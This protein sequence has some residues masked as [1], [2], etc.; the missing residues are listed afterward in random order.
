MA[1]LALFVSYQDDY[2][3]AFLS[4]CYLIFWE[5]TH[6]MTHTENSLLCLPTPQKLV[7]EFD[8]L[9]TTPPKIPPDEEGLLWGWCVVRGPLK[10]KVHCKRRGSE[11]SIVLASVSG[12][13]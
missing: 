6:G 9:H 2:T 4:H 3:H 10:N 8:N 1:W 7:F 13:F 5:P 12:S 11:M